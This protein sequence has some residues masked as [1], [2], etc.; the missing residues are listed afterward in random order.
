MK[1]VIC[2]VFATMLSVGSLIAQDA[3]SESAIDYLIALNEKTSSYDAVEINLSFFSGDN[4]DETPLSEGTV[5]IKGNEF[6]MKTND[7]ITVQTSNLFYYFDNSY[8]NIN[9]D[10]EVFIQD[11]PTEQIPF[12]KLFPFKSSNFD[13]YQVNYELSTSSHIYIDLITNFINEPDLKS[14]IFRLIFDIE[15]KELFRFIV[16]KDD[17]SILADEVKFTLNPDLS[18]FSF[19]FGN[20]KNPCEGNMNFIDLREY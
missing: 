7:V 14:T 8:D 6:Y 19:I 13:K 1:K 20:G 2:Y 17:I 10:C 12:L 5:L 11:I 9:T 3:S 4:E 15:K 18:E 16:I